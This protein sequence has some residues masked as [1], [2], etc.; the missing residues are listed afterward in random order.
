MTIREL[1]LKVHSR[2]D[3]ACDHC[4]VYEHADQS[5]RRTP[6]LMAGRTVRQVALRL[7]EYAH[8]Q[9]LPSVAVVLHGGEP[10]LAGPARL[11]SICAELT[12]ALAPATRLDLSVHTNGVRLNRAHLTVFEEFGVKVGISLDGDRAANDRHRLDHRGRSSYDRVRR[13]IDLL[14]LPEYR[15][16]FQGLLCTVDVAGDP[17]VVH[18]ALTALEP[19]LVDYLLPHATWDVPPPPGRAGASTPYADW[20]LRVFDRWDG[21]GRQVPVRTFDSILSTLRGGPALAEALGLPPGGIAVVETDGTITRSDSLKIA[22][23]GAPATGYDVFRN[24][25]TEFARGTRDPGPVRSTESTESIHGTD[26]TD[27][28]RS[29]ESTESTESTGPAGPPSAPAGVSETCRRCRVLAD[30][31]GGLYAHR[32]RTGRG[33]DNPSVYCADL[34]ALIEGIAE[35]ITERALAPAVTSA[36]ELGRARLRLDRAL[37]ADVN[38]ALAGDASWDEAWRLLVR[39]D[40]DGRTAPHLDAVVTHP[41][42]RPSLLDSW[43]GRADLPRFMAVAAAAALRAGVEATLRWDQPDPLV[44][45]PTLGTV[46]L[47]GAGRVEF[48]LGADGLRVGGAPQPGAP[49]ASPPVLRAWRPLA[50]LPCGDGRTLTIDDADPFRDCFP[51]AVTPPLDPGPL[52]AFRD[53]LATA[54]GLLDER[55]PGWRDGANASTATT[56]TPLAAG[57][58]LHLGTCGSGALGV[59]IDVEPEDFARELPRLGRRAR[60]TALREVVDLHLPG[61]PA[62]RLLDLASEHIGAAARSSP[63]AAPARLL[64]GRVLGELSGLPP[65]ELTEN[66]AYL[67]EELR[68]EWT[69]L[70]D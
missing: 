23:D 1:V 53:R 59:A 12:G 40:A 63:D 33:F 10:L 18:D 61:S 19:P 11:R 7:A 42:L 24:S 69:A 44:H 67:A 70:R 20:L 34:R 15:H 41:Y 31:G 16:L 21:Q 60:L 55:E 64:A 43:D 56:L 8:E 65:R 28:V 58:G 51:A 35:R 22:Y 14:R 26:G 48:R 4:Y 25:F 57:S 46:R 27:G 30:C 5:W 37:L 45:L 39:L 38:T 49:G 32:Y 68:A 3:L 52:D 36:G 2:C 29:T 17:V 54:Y 13:G 9:R 47:S 62:E 50:S 6:P 66:G